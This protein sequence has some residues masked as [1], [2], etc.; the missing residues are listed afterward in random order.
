VPLSTQRLVRNQV[1]CRE[2]N[3]RLRGPADVVPDGHADYLCECS[4]V[5][6][7][8]KIELELSEYEAVRARPRTFFIV[9]GH[10]RFEVDRVVDRNERYTIVEKIVPLDDAATRAL[11]TTD[12]DWAKDGR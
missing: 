10:E 6:C 4:D 7:T 1:I 3:E 12:E 8:L 9:P 2:V 11:T 5:G